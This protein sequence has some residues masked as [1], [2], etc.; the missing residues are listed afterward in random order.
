MQITVKGTWLGACGK[1]A[2]DRT[3][4]VVQEVPTAAR[5]GSGFEVMYTVQCDGAL[6]TVA[7][8]RL[9]GEK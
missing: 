2:A 5:E 9:V 6:W 1:G 4:E 3:F 8:C 7:K